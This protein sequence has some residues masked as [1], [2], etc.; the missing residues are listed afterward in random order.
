MKPGFQ[1]ITGTSKEPDDYG[2]SI[3]VGTAG[4]ECKVSKPCT[5][6]MGVVITNTDST[7]AI[8]YDMASIA[9]TTKKLVPTST[10]R[11]GTIA[12]GASVTIYAQPNVRI[13]LA[14]SASTVAV[15]VR[16]FS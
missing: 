15:Y 16:E 10:K 7:N 4:A 2:T 13:F 14:A 1:R 3:S 9:D 5:D 6:R 11:L 12:A 8:Y